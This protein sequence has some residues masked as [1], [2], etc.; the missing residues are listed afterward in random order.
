V[1]RNLLVLFIFIILTFPAYKALRHMGMISGHDTEAAMFKAEEFFNAIKDGN[2]PP[3]WAKRLDYGLGQPTFVFTYTMPYY[4]M[5]IPMILNTGSIWAFKII[6]GASFPFSAFFAYLWLCKHFRKVPAIIGGLIYTYVPYHMANVYVRGAIGETVA[7]M[8]LPLAFWGLDKVIDQPNLV[9]SAMAALTM[10]AV[11]LSHPFYGLV[12]AAGWLFYILV[13]AGKN[14]NTLKWAIIALAWGYIACSFYIIPAWADKNLTFLDRM[15][16][17]FLEKQYFVTLD[18]IIYSPWGF[19]GANESDK[20]PM[21]VQAGLVSLAFFMAWILTAVFNKKAR[22][23]KNYSTGVYFAVIS[24]ISG[25]M[26][27]SISL[28]IW[29]LLPMLQNLQFPWR[30]LFVVNI[31]TTFCAAAVLNQWDL[32]KIG[33]LKKGL[34]ITGI[35]LAIIL[36]D[37]QYWNVERY[38]PYEDKTTT[39]IGYPGTLTMLLEETPKWH[40]RDQEANPHNFIQNA[41]VNTKAITLT[42]LIWK[43]NYHKFEVVTDKAEYINDKTHYWPGWKVRVDGVEVPL[44]NPYN[45]LSQGLIT[46]AVTPGK[47]I[48][49]SRLT[50]P[51]INYIS[52]IISVI[53][54]IAAVALCIRPVLS[55]KK[56]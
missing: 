33:I 4:L 46:F 48:V 23:E 43:T 31:G 39:A 9:N 19:A 21:S 35:I 20:D 17:Y 3:R 13:R 50:E 49:E 34:I 24:V 41:D 5:M 53:S 40:Q 22:Q 52:D 2:F 7:A 18:R 37:R 55:L 29:K 10:A 56:V 44:L 15:G 1:K 32:L 6:M 45:K 14:V 51:P 42:S 16:D 47:H 36:T 25:F 27:L 28:P 30:M 54:I 8:F 12:F 11:I 38:F 26:M